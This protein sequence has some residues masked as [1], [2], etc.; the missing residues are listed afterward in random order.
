MNME[1]YSP[2]NNGHPLSVIYLRIRNLNRRAG[3]LLN[4]AVF[5]NDV[6]I[7]GPRWGQDFSSC[8]FKEHRAET[9]N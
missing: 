3:N 9:I 2:G 4:D 6:R 5:D 1:V 7:D 8:N